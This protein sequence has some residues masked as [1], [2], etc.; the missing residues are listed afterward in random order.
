[1]NICAEIASFSRMSVDQ[2][3]SRGQAELVLR[4]A[5]FKQARAILDVALAFSQ[6]A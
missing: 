5:A 6:Q 1:L 2:G 3:L 4:E